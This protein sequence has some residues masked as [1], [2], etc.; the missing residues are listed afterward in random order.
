[1]P[2]DRDEPYNRK[3]KTGDWQRSLDQLGISQL[4]EMFGMGRG[5]QVT[6][7][8]PP[9]GADG[10]K[11]PINILEGLGADRQ[12]AVDAAAARAAEG[13]RVP[14]RGPSREDEGGYNRKWEEG[15]WQDSLDQLGISNLLEM[16][17]MGGAPV[18]SR[19][20]DRMPERFNRLD[21]KV[22]AE[23]SRGSGVTDQAKL[24]RMIQAQSRPEV[25]QE[26]LTQNLP[27][28][29]V[30]MSPM[31]SMLPDWLLKKLQRPNQVE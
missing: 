12:R 30:K 31:L 9:E 24:Y 27:S 1:M 23:R 15:D 3:W 17:G 6:G 13:S 25:Q 16:F 5:P 4:M 8:N 11:V 18:D 22:M 26:A 7:R 20:T 19:R 28:G 2:F 14:Y 21:P 10:P 29:T